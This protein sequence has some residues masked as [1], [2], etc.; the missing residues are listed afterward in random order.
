MCPR[1]P[2]P[3]TPEWA[4]EAGEL[5]SLLPGVPGADGT[6]TLSVAVAPRK[7][8]SVH[9]RYESGQV[10]AGGAGAGEAAALTLTTN[11]ADAADLLAGRV[12]P[13]VAFMRGRLK[14]AGE[15]GLLLG[16]LASTATEG[17]EAWRSRVGA[18]S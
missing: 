14:A 18:V 12:D 6:V 2:D 15:G 3:G 5:W 9:W 4:A 8:A 16:F 17:F 10:V 13:S 7:E 11:A 1:V